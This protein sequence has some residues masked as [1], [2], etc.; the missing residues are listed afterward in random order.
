MLGLGRFGGIGGSF[1]VAELSARQFVFGETFAI[2][3]SAGVVAA[4][5]LLAK[6]AVHPELTADTPLG[7]EVMGH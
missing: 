3:G 7:E 1:P 2:V 6:Q 4:G 5:A